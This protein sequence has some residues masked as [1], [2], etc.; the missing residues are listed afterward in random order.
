MS[1]L[2]L[3]P[4]HFLLT[5]VVVVVAVVVVFRLVGVRPI[6][7]IAGLMYGRILRE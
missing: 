1:W 5:V 7:M 6:A 4:C 3:D 2:Y